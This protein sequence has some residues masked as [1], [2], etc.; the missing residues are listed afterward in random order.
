MKVEALQSIPGVFVYQSFC[1]AD[2]RGMFVKTYHVDWASRLGLEFE[3]REEFY[4]VSMRGVLRGMHFQTPPYAHQKL[5]YCISGRILDVLVDLRCGEGFGQVWSRELSATS[6]EVLWVPPGIA[7]GFLSLE[8]NSIVVYKT[9]CEYA[10][11]NDGGIH[12]NSFGFSW[13]ETI[14]PIVTSDRD[15]QHPKLNEFVSPFGESQEDS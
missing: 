1:A 2:E 15:K 4:S 10:P 11:S 7:H 12:W 6:P 14:V 9:D 8:D 13:P 3:F 5:V